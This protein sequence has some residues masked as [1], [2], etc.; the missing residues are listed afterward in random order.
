MT[1]FT[2]HLTVNLFIFFFL[3]IRRPPR[4]TLFPYTTLFRSAHGPRPRG[5][6]RRALAYLVRGPGRASRA[7]ALRHPARGHAPQPRAPPT[8][9]GRAA[10]PGVRGVELGGARGRGGRGPG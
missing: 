8:L 2:F 7:R 6:R 10:R 4:S 1:R 3:M 5:R 9:E